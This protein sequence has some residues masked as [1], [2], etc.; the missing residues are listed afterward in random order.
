MLFIMRKRAFGQRWEVVE[1]DVSEELDDSGGR[2]IVG[3]IHP[4]GN[5]TPISF[6]C[7]MRRG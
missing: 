3:V 4:G 2:Q 5:D 6:A 1:A 7:A